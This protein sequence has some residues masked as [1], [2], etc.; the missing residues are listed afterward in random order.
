MGL[1]W[2]AIFLGKY[3]IFVKKWL[4]NGHQIGTLVGHVGYRNY[5]FSPLGP[6][7]CPSGAQWRPKWFQGCPKA[8]KIELKWSQNATQGL[9]N[10]GP[11]APMVGFPLRYIYIYATV[12]S[13][14]EVECWNVYVGSAD[15][16]V[17]S[18]DHCF[19]LYV[20]IRT[21]PPPFGTQPCA[22][23]RDFLATLFQGSI[24]E[25]VFPDFGAPRPPKMEPN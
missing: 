3:A 25:R 23:L 4:P 21:P 13:W 15:P 22:T 11:R 24:L 5:L 20:F 16:C 6:Q 9:Q 1:L 12:P 8:G 14:H 18:V 17:G 10:V 7:G 2:E 19:M